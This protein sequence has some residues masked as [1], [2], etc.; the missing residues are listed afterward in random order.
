M[1]PEVIPGQRPHQGAGDRTSA[2]KNV[3]ALPGN[4]ALQERSPTPL[5]EAPRAVEDQT[6][7]DG[8][9]AT[10]PPI[11]PAAPIEVNIAKERKGQP[12]TPQPGDGK[13]G[14]REALDSSSPLEKDD[15]GKRAVEGPGEGF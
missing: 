8:A 14:K 10:F 5:R 7:A 3:R 15:E 13:G 12:I 11:P 1:S 9:R 4:V 6:A 2:L